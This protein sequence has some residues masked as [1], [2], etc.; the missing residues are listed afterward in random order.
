MFAKQLALDTNLKE[1]MAFSDSSFPF[2][3]CYDDFNYKVGQSLNYHWHETIELNVM[4]EGE[5]DY[6]LNDQRFALTAGD[7]MVVYSNTLHGAVLS[8]KNPEARM[9]TMVFSADL[10]TGGVAGAVQ[11]KYF[12]SLSDTGFLGTKLVKDTTIAEKLRPLLLALA[13]EEREKIGYELRIVAQ[14][15]LIWD[16]LFHYLLEQD[17]TLTKRAIKYEEEIKAIMVYIQKNYMNRL[18]IQRL[19]EATGI[20]RSE[21]FRIFARFT[22]KKPM[23]Y[24]NDYRMSLAV[25]MMLNTQ[26]TVDRIALDC[27]FQSPSYFGKL[28]KE[29]YNQT[30]KQFRTKQK[31]FENE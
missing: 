13:K 23:E 9:L 19:C 30:P 16:Q 12:Q 4:L 8:E 22:Q 27:G 28:F 25:A 17:Q 24:I 6:R 26:Q 7:C 1:L 14:L 20:S 3:F 11:Q 2:E 31:R 15:S 29:R 10:L 5:I 18:T 21:C